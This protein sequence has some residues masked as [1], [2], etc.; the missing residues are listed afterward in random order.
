M[1]YTDNCPGCGQ[2]V[3]VEEDTSRY[4][5]VIQNKKGDV[6]KYCPGCHKELEVVDGEMKVVEK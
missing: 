3:I 5:Y 6:I 2:E 1:R 4:A